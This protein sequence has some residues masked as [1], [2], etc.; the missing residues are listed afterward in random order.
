V[1]CIVDGDDLRVGN[2]RVG[3][4]AHDSGNGSGARRLG[5]GCAGC[6]E[7]CKNHEDLASAEGGA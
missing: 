5:V 3:R 1:G 6:Q 7:P 2:G 4:I